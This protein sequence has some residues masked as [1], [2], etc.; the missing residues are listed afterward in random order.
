[1]KNKNSIFWI[2]GILQAV[3]LGLITFFILQSL[4]SLGKD[5]QIILSILFPLFLLIVEYIIYSKR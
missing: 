4:G 1:M 5:T 3:T 2:F